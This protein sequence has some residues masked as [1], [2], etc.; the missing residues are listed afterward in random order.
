MAGTKSSSKLFYENFLL[1]SLLEHRL[2][3]TVHIHCLQFDGL[4]PLDI[5]LSPT[6]QV[7]AIK[8]VILKEEPANFHHDTMVVTYKGKHLEDYFQLRD[9]GIQDGARVD[10]LVEQRQVWVVTERDEHYLVDVEPSISIWHLKQ[11]VEAMTG[12]SPQ[13]FEL[14]LLNEKLRDSLELSDYAVKQKSKLQMVTKCT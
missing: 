2:E 11:I 10:V 1:E 8:D 13:D 6:Q 5:C 4:E 12:V 3:I 7:R 14:F 9:Y